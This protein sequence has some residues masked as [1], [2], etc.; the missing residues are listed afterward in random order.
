MKSTLFILMTF[1]TLTAQAQVKELAENEPAYK[2]DARTHYIKVIKDIEPLMAA[3][4]IYLQNNQILT[5]KEVD[6]SQVYCSM[7][8]VRSQ[9]ET[10]A[11]E[12]SKGTTYKIEDND[13]NFKS[14]EK[15]L[16]YRIWQKGMI[17]WDNGYYQF[18]DC[19]ALNT[20]NVLNY[21]TLKK[22][23]GKFLRILK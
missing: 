18:L 1:L 2:L 4:T 5:Y 12:I 9:D 22:H 13:D 14:W 17:F 10:I 11:K 6:Q 20:N 16:S 3:K 15:F 19:S 7:E 21:G 8:N 23:I